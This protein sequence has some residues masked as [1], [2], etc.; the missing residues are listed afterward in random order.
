[1]DL[2]TTSDLEVGCPQGSVLSPFLWNVLVDPVLRL[3]FSF[4]FSV[5]AYADDLVFVS[6]HKNISTA[7]ANLQLMCDAVATWCASVKLSL[8]GSK[9]IYMVFGSKNP[10]QCIAM[11]GFSIPPSQSCMYLGICIDSKLSWRPHLTNLCLAVKK[12]TLWIS[13]LVRRTWGLSSAKLKILYNC[14]FVSSFTYCCSV[15]TGSLR[16][17]TIV[18]LLRSA[19]RFLALRIAGVF[20]STASQSAC[21]LANILPIDYKIK[22]TASLRALTP[23]LCLLIPPST[24]F[25]L[26]PL[27]QIIRNTENFNNL[28]HSKVKA[29]V[30]LAVTSLWNQEWLG[31]NGSQ[32]THSFFPSV[33]SARSMLTLKP[34]FE[35]SQLLGGHSLLNSHQFKIKKCPSPMCSCGL[36]TESI[37]HFIFFCPSHTD[38]RKYFVECV[39]SLSISWPPPLF[40]LISIPSLWSAFSLFVISSRRLRRI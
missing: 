26:F 1:M 18:A 6:H 39:N 30:S 17:K 4:P 14:L 10:S 31:S 21:I 28:H 36:D 37:E 9:T 29:T 8:N 2:S 22:E 7:H 38:T 11:D 15:W 35:L 3:T 16:K 33:L 5:V 12:K 32:I 27:L 20:H 19:Q 24:S 40:L 25:V 13:N 34:S 23:H